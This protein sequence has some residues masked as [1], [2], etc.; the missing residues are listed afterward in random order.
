MALLKMPFSTIVT[1]DRLCIKSKDECRVIKVHGDYEHPN[2]MV[3]T[4]RDYDRFL[5]NNPIMATY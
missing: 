5:V 2:K 4:E 1:E 3:I